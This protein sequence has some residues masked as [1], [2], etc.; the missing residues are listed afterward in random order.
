MSIAEPMAYA[1]W[2][3][4]GQLHSWTSSN[5]PD[6]GNL[7][8]AQPRIKKYI[9]QSA[10][11]TRQ[12]LPDRRYKR[13]KTAVL[14]EDNSIIVF[15]YAKRKKKRIERELQCYVMDAAVS[16][17]PLAFVPVLI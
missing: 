5:L 11:E 9:R 10:C 7:D 2:I 8:H 6:G 17:K 15:S 14:N 12:I 16:I 4:T 3:F 1:T 13:K